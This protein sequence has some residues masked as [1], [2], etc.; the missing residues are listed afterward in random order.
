MFLS[1]ENIQRIVN[2]PFSD[3]TPIEKEKLLLGKYSLEKQLNEKLA[4]VFH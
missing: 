2:N 3:L 4:I 1:Q